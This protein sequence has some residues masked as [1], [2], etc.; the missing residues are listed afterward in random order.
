M[1][2][3]TE[4]QIFHEGPSQEQGPERNIGNLRTLAVPERCQTRTSEVLFSPVKRISQ[5]L[6]ETTVNYY[7]CVNTIVFV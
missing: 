4:P 3:A 6:C 7:T 5:K 1:T 2:R